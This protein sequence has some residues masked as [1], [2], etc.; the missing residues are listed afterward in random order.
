[1]NCK[2]IEKW[3]FKTPPVMQ[4]LTVNKVLLMKTSYK[5]VNIRWY[6]IWLCQGHVSQSYHLQ[7]THNSKSVNNIFNYSTC[8]KEKKNEEKVKEKEKE[9]ELHM[10][11]TIYMLKIQVSY[12]GTTRTWHYTILNTQNIVQRVGYGFDWVK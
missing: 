12:S 3:L 5:T 6:K 10:H 8:G 4:N 11:K 9:R 2:K 7:N 1:M